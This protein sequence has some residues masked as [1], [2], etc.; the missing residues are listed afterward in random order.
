M[1]LT[2]K[3]I[4]QI[5]REL[6][7]MPPAPRIRTSMSRAEAIEQISAEILALRRSGYGLKALAAL[8]SAKGLAGC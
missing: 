3:R 6:S 8:L 7:A 4:E 1:D 5:R 2:L